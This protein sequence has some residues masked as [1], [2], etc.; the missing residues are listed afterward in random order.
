MYSQ[1]ENCDKTRV[2]NDTPLNYLVSTPVWLICRQMGLER[3]KE[4]WVRRKYPS[5]SLQKR[6]AD[7]FPNV[8][9]PIAESNLSRNKCDRRFNLSFGFVAKLQSLQVLEKV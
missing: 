5:L 7:P 2:I 8:L 1:V 3:C 6:F 4:S 9:K